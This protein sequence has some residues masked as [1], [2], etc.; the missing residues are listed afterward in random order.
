MTKTVLVRY[1]AIS[2][3]ARFVNASG[4]SLRRGTEVVVQSHRGLERG[5]LLEDAADR[6][7]VNGNGADLAE[8]P[9]IKRPCTVDDRRQGDELR[10]ECEADF[11]PWQARIRDWNLQLELIDLERTL[12][13]S[14]LILY[15]LNDRGADCTRLALQA[16]AAG[17]GVV[18]VQSV[19]A[20]GLVPTPSGHGCGSGGCGSGGESNGCCH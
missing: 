9:E 6:D 3:V 13:R 17:F 14:K 16:A 11:G 7:G 15:V 18:E 12:D 1:G 19:G 2:E 20:D 4:Q 10:S 8:E 5:V